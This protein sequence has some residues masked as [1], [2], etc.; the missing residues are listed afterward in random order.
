MPWLH[1][2][3]GLYLEYWKR[4]MVIITMDWQGRYVIRVWNIL[5][6]ESTTERY[7]NGSWL[8][9]KQTSQRIKG[10]RTFKKTKKPEFTMRVKSGILRIGTECDRDMCKYL[11]TLILWFWYPILLIIPCASLWKCCAQNNNCTP[12]LEAL[13]TLTRSIC[14]EWAWES[15]MMKACD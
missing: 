15:G 12:L 2:I 1:D 7:V 9:R 10:Q 13:H 3:S 11:T 8:S 5:R 14:R 6:C 4:D